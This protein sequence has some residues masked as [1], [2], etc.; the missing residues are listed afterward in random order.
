[1]SSFFWKLKK[2]IP[3]L[4]FSVQFLFGVFG[5]IWLRKHLD[6][7][8]II[9]KMTIKSVLQIIFIY[10][11]LFAFYILL[12]LINAQLSV[13]FNLLIFGLFMNIISV[14]YSWELLR[15]ISD[16]ALINGNR[17]INKINEYKRFFQFLFVIYGILSVSYAISHFFQW[18][19]TKKKA[20]KIKL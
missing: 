8:K 10:S 11:L 5:L 13:R 16:L 14:I 3:I 1:M 15:D 18:I 9:F 20:I 19:S 7:D 17:R 6:T 2:T 12:L 4:S